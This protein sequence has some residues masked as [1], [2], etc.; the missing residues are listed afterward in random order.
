MPRFETVAS[1][2]KYYKPVSRILFFVLPS[3]LRPAQCSGWQRG[4]HLSVQSIT[5]KDQ[6]AYPSARTSSPLPIVS[7]RWPMWHFSMQGLPIGNVT[8]TNREL[9]PHVFTLPSFPSP[10]CGEGKGM[11]LFSVALSVPDESE[12]GSSPVHCSALS[13]LSYPTYIE[14]IAWLAAVR[15]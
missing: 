7:V 1:W 14:S 5:W 10:P 2:I 13:G 8:I 15:R 11:R 3:P 6:S 9:L 4:Y 12:P